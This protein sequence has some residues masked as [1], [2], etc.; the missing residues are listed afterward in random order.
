MGMQ[1]EETI[2]KY[3]NNCWKNLPIFKILKDITSK[4]KIVENFR[5]RARGDTNDNDLDKMREKQSEIE[6][7]LNFLEM[8]LHNLSE[9]NKRILTKIPIILLI[10][11]L[12][13]FCISKFFIL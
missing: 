10:L 13:V 9:D 12:V 7:K 3:H 6:N 2:F 1:P 8:H 11:L 4:E 5:E